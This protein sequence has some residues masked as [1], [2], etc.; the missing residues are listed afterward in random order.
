MNNKDYTEK[1]NFFF[2]P[3]LS[4]I[5][6]VLSFSQSLP[7]VPVVPNEG[8]IEGKVVGYCV[9]S[10]VVLNIKPDSTFYRLAILVTASKSTVGKPNFARDKSGGIIEVY[11]REKLSGNFFN[12]NINARIMYRGDEKGGLYWIK[13]INI[14]NTEKETK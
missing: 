12:Q 13:N 7:A 3:V 2:G 14:L 10:S 4:A 11:S 9:I 8:I 1:T 6:L 5:I